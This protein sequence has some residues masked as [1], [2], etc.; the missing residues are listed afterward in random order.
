MATKMVAGAKSYVHLRSNTV[1][2]FISSKPDFYVRWGITI[3]AILLTLT[4]VVCWFIRYPE[5]VQSGGTLASVNPPR[6]VI[7]KMEGR[8]L[9]LFVT[10]GQTVQ[11]DEVLGLLESTADHA[12]VL[13]LSNELDRTAL[14]LRQHN[15]AEIPVFMQRE[16]HHLGELQAA[17]QSFIQSYMLFRD[18]LPNGAYY[19][20]LSIISKEMGVLQ[21]QEQN[22]LQQKELE[23]KD[24]ALLEKSIDVN[25]QLNK[26]QHLSDMDMRNEESRLISKQLSVPQVNAALLSNQSQRIQ[27]EKESLDLRDKYIVELTAF[28]QSLH[29]LRALVEDWKKKYL[30]SAPV[31]GRF[32]FTSFINE[33]QQMKTGQQIGFVTPGNSSYYAEVVIPQPNFGKIKVSQDVLLKLPAYPSHEYGH[34]TGKLVFISPLPTDSG[35]LAKVSLPDTLVTNYQK[36]IQYREGLVFQAEIITSDMRLLERFYQSLLKN[37]RN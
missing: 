21:Q 30:L 26:E 18:Y 24:L 13:R 22:I 8:L 31:E 36:A 12:Q 11:K 37:V 27:K 35:Y 28:T 32:A 2:E 16:D 19:R 9:K 14:L 23:Q 6:P 7:S 34:L 10:E 29:T 15:L 4:A 1:Q 5:V 20:K 33:Q 3:F 25:R 17:Y